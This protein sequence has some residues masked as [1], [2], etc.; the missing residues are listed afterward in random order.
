MAKKDRTWASW[1]NWESKYYGRKAQ[2]R[3]K[4][5]SSTDKKGALAHDRIKALTKSMTEEQKRKF[6]DFYEGIRPS[7]KDA[8][9]S[10]EDLDNL[11]AIGDVFFSGGDVI[12]FIG[13]LDDP[14][15]GIL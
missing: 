12:D 6:R 1:G 5:N 15:E 4:W 8:Q 3:R 9:Y 10:E 14:L 2:Y 7:E 13:T 11:F